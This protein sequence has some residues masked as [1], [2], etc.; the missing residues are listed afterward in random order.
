MTVKTDLN[1][2]M[3]NNLIFNIKN[4]RKFMNLNKF[5]LFIIFAY[6]VTPFINDSLKSISEVFL[7]VYLFYLFVVNPGSF[8]T[9]KM[10]LLFFS[11]VI[12]QIL[13]WFFL[14]YSNPEF[15]YHVPKVDRLG[16]L[17]LF[18]PIAWGLKNFNNNVIK[19]LSVAAIVCFFAGLFVHS[20]FLLEITNAFKGQRV[21]FGIRNAQHPSM[22]FG[23]IFI[24]SFF[25]LF[26]FENKNRIILFLF[27]LF[28]IISFAGIVFTQTRQ[29]YFALASGG[30]FTCLLAYFMK[31]KVRKKAVL[32]AM[33]VICSLIFSINMDNFFKRLKAEFSISS[34]IVNYEENKKD[35]SGFEEKIDFIV[36]NIPETSTGIRLKSIIESLKWIAKK[37]LF[38]WGSDGRSIVISES[39]NFSERSRIKFGHLHNYFFEVLVSYG[40]LGFSIIIMLYYFI[41]RGVKKLNL[42]SNDNSKGLYVITFCFV[43]Y[44]LIMNNFESYNSFWTGVFVHN[45]VCG[46]IYSRYLY[47]KDELGF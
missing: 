12:V 35:L 7:G 25:Y 39:N 38:G 36:K 4:D 26:I 43:I 41:L 46:C 30:F 29:T 27:L 32:L 11:A 3:L 6:S 23:V 20:D 45:F 16:K 18:I 10:T 44:W 8:R 15:A 34:L 1:N 21:D 19:Y 13:S 9:D 40:L 14:K 37:P 5:V 47:T 31:I 24:F 22:V 42:A 28:I 33:M 2:S 17:F